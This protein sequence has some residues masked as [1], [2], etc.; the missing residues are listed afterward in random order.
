MPRTPTKIDKLTAERIQAA[1][2]K[3]ESLTKAAVL[4][5]GC[6]RGTVKNWLVAAGRW[7]L[8][9]RLTIPPAPQRTE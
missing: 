5:L 7:P 3:H 6:S 4:E 1:L 2:D 8:V 9:R